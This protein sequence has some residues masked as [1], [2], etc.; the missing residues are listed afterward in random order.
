MLGGA[1]IF[2]DFDCAQDLG[3]L[4]QHIRKSDVLLIFLRVEVILRPG[5]ILEIHAAVSA[6]IPLVGVTL[7]GKDYDHA[8]AQRQ[9][10]CLN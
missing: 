8:E 10:T 2:L 6:G 4:L 1:E 9:L 7:R 3:T 5:C